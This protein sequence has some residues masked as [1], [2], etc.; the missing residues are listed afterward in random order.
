MSYTVC[1]RLVSAPCEEQG[2]S[3]EQRESGDWK[4]GSGQAG[5]DAAWQSVREDGAEDRQ[6][7]YT[8]H[9]L[10]QVCT[11]AYGNSKHH[12]LFLWYRQVVQRCDTGS[13]STC[14][15]LNVNYATPPPTPTPPPRLL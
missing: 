10:V 1:P 5:A 7:H 11:D 9:I 4:T 15:G 3:R 12:L 14:Y 13:K 8:T 2:H 6:T